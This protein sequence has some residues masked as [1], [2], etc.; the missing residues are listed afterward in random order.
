MLLFH[1]TS[2]TVHISDS[3]CGLSFLVSDHLRR[4]P[5]VKLLTSSSASVMTLLSAAKLP[6][7]Q[8]ACEWL[9]LRVFDIFIR[10]SHDLDLNQG[11]RKD[12]GVPS[13]L[14][15][16][17]SSPLLP[18]MDPHPLGEEQPCIDAFCCQWP[19]FNPILPHS[20]SN[21]IFLSRATPLHPHYPASTLQMNFSHQCFV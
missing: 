10:L 21:P 12:E 13:L 20:A 16:L 17:C 15:F 8:C 2:P 18:V 6:V 11:Y 5:A 14:Y 7:Y 3:L 4:I 19:S 1:S 9:S